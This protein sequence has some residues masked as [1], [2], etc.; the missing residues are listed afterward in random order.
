MQRLRAASG[1]AMCIAGVLLAPVASAQLRGEM[2][3]ERIDGG[4]M[5]NFRQRVRS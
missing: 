3:R 2:I 1:F 4:R 5:S